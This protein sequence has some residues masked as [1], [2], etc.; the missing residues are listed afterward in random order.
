MSKINVKTSLG[1]IIQK[2][3][4]FLDIETTGLI[5]GIQEIIEI[6]AIDIEGNV[7][8]EAKILPTNISTAQPR[9]LEVNRYSE[10]AWSNSTHLMTLKDALIAL[11]PVIQDKV[12]VGSNPTFDIPFL[13]MAYAENTLATLFQPYYRCIDVAILAMVFT[14]TMSGLDRIAKDL[15]IS[16]PPNRHSAIAD[17]EMTRLVFLALLAAIDSARALEALLSE[18]PPTADKT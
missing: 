14:G 17:C 7:L 8:L 10:H 9:A 15:G 5:P 6:G 11:A 13:R 12:I 16:A 4:V 3:A 2:D 1:T 18:V